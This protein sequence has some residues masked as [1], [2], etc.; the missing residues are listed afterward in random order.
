[1]KRMTLVA[2]ALAALCLCP[3]GARA[4]AVKEDWYGSWAMNHDGHVGTLIISD[5]PADCAA[6]VWCDMRL[7]YQDRNGTRFRGAIVN[8]DSQLQHMAFYISFP[9]NRQRFDAYIFSWDKRK[10]AGTTLWG[11]RTFGFYA[12][13]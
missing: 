2:L 13:R 11:G 1:M 8:I 6:P 7:V 9:G 3:A 10:L 5:S 4:D 12:S